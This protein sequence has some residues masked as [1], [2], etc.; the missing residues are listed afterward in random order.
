MSNYHFW[1]LGLSMTFVGFAYAIVVFTALRVQRKI[2]ETRHRMSRADR[3]ANRQL[4][5]VMLLQALVPIVST[6]PVLLVCA[7]TLFDL[8]SAFLPPLCLFA[9]ACAP[10]ANGCVVIGVIPAFRRVVLNMLPGRYKFETTTDLSTRNSHSGPPAF[11]PP[12]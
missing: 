9:A 3:A 11:H 1:H 7:S 2:H 8:Q 12:M 10:V 4:T 6:S 5:L